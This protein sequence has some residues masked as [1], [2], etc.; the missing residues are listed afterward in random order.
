LVFTSHSTCAMVLHP[1]QQVAHVE[2]IAIGTDD[3]LG[4]DHPSLI[5]AALTSPPLANACS[6]TSMWPNWIKT[7]EHACDEAS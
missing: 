1:P 4:Q 6:T 7:S 2:N 5:L 3:S